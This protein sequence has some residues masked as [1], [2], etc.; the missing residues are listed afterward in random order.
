MDSGRINM[1]LGENEHFGKTQGSIFWQGPTY[2]GNLEVSSLCVWPL[3]TAVLTK[4]K[5]SSS[6]V[7]SNTILL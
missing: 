6:E 2:I 7:D 3:D 5:T 1:M 4:L